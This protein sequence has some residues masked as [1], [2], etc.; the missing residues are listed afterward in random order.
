MNTGKLVLAFVSR[1]PFTWAFHVLTLA[2]GVGVVVAIV[3]LSQALDSRFARDLAGVDLVVG[4]KGSP[5]QLIMS[6]LLQI[7]I[8]TGNIPLSVAENLAANKLVAA[9]A[10]VSVGD[11][12]RGLRIVGTTQ[13]YAALYEAT[14]D[15]G[16]WWT[17]PMEVVLGA[18][19]ARELGLGLGGTFVGQH[20]L[21]SGGEL[22]VEF[23]YVIVGILKPTGA[24]IDNLVLTD[25]E[26]V[27]RIHEHEAAE[28]AAEQ[29]NMT[30]QTH[31]RAVTAL[32]VRYKSSMGAVMLPKLAAAMPDIQAAVPAVE[33]AR[34]RALLGTGAEILR[35][36]GLGLLVLSSAG[37]VVA[38]SGAV[39]RRQRELALLRVLGS[40]RFHLIGIVLTEA[41][42]LGLIGGAVG[43]ALGR[44]L[45]MIAV[46][47][48]AVSGGPHL[49]LNPIGSVDL[50]ALAIAGSLSLIA[51]IGPAILAYRQGA[52]EALRP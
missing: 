12:V 27:W 24:V 40:A 48:T 10:M 14:L 35:W 33:V 13:D 2:L 39:Q 19:A 44:G 16:G 3:L 43:T 45:A 32:L 36:F 8:P 34:L 38:L 9:S 4:A 23:P 41:L 15:Q 28:A 29:G 5:L 26:S 52:A 46:Q 31:E 37:F 11:N 42:L 20:G 47:T 21:T 50:A 17:K 7:D 51:A 6:S 18:A 30:H 25:R 22:H 49:L 1:N